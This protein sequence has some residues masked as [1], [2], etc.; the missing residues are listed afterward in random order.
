[1]GNYIC[2]D[3]VPFTEDDVRITSG[4]FPSH[5]I[6]NTDNAIPGN[7]LELVKLFKDFDHNIKA[8]RFFV[9]EENSKLNES[10][11]SKTSRRASTVSESKASK[12]RASTTSAA[13]GQRPNH[14]NNNNN[15]NNSTNNTNNND[16]KVASEPVT[17]SKPLVHLS[18]TDVYLVIQI[19]RFLPPSTTATVN[20]TS[21][22]NGSLTSLPLPTVPRRQKEEDQDRYKGGGPAVVTG[23]V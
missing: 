7:T 16:V 19:H 6:G 14:N 18:D 20:Y 23:Y 15:N 13:S 10:S 4:A 2:T 8:F 22:P 1:M 11:T 17:L 9:E 3:G 21:G 5:R 12:R